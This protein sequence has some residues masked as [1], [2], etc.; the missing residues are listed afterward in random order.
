VPPQKPKTLDGKGRSEGHGSVSP[1]EPFTSLGISHQLLKELFDAAR[2]RLTSLSEE[3]TA[4]R[5]IALVS[6]VRVLL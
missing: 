2:V 3:R 4:D 6:I 5:C 1:T